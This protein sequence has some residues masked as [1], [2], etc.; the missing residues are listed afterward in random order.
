MEEKPSK[1]IETSATLES[2]RSTPLTMSDSFAVVFPALQWC[3][4]FDVNGW[5]VIAHV[6]RFAFL[7]NTS[8]GT[9]KRLNKEWNKL[10]HLAHVLSSAELGEL[11]EAL[12]VNRRVI[13]YCRA[14]EPQEFMTR[15]TCQGAALNRS[16]CSALDYPVISCNHCPETF[17]FIGKHPVW[18]ESKIHLIRF[19]LTAHSATPR[20][21]LHFG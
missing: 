2:K 1:Q 13:Y 6:E 8:R 14:Q 7:K 12:F 11:A 18:L 4:K 10:Y 16:K 21:T 3:V 9:W 5:P 20:F 17:S 19:Y 15:E